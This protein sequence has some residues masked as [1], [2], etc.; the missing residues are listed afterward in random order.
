[1]NPSLKLQILVIVC[2]PFSLWSQANFEPY[3]ISE[4]HLERTQTYWS[5]PSYCS[6]YLD[7]SLVG[8][9]ESLELVQLNGIYQLQYKRIERDTILSISK[10]IDTS[11]AKSLH[12]LFV[13]A[14]LHVEYRPTNTGYKDGSHQY[15]RCSF[16]GHH[17]DLFGYTYQADHGNLERFSLLMQ[18]LIALCLESRKH[19]SKTE[20]QADLD[21]LAN[22]MNSRNLIRVDE[23]SENIF[24][25]DY[26]F[27]END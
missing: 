24:N 18:E 14:L 13:I 6:W 16:W 15:L 17:G 21:E 8:P 23:E 2:L 7:K 10:A 22:Q 3:P 25:P 5:D 20:L 11:L 12:R 4:Q 26:Q 9:D 1:M 19:K 27:F